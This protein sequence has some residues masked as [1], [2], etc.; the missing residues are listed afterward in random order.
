MCHGSRNGP[1][2]EELYALP[3]GKANVKRTGGDVTVIATMAMVPRA[4]RRADA[5]S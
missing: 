4:Q 3:I 1:V 2:S 5:D